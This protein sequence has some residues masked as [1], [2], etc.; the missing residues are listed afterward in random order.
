MKAFATLLVILAVS[1]CSTSQKR[2][3]DAKRGELIREFQ[4]YYN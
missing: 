3:V 4:V 2:V 1:A